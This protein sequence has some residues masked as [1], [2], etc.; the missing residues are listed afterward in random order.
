MK[1]DVRRCILSKRRAI[2]CA[3][4]DFPVPAR[5][6]RTRLRS[7]AGSFTQLTM[8]FRKAVRVPVRQPLSGVNREPIPY[9]ISLIFA[10]SS[11]MIIRSITQKPPSH[12]EY[13]PASETWLDT[14]SSRVDT[15]STLAESIPTSSR[16]WNAVISVVMTAWSKKAL[17]C[18]TR[19][20]DRASISLVAPPPI[21]FNV[22]FPTNHTF[23]PAK[24][25][26]EDNI[27]NCAS[28]AYDRITSLQSQTS[29]SMRERFLACFEFGLDGFDSV[30]VVSE[31]KRVVHGSN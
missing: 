29:C 18:S 2:S 4:D 11:I 26:D 19:A 28:F 7:E 16:I 3:I 6:K 14:H 13:V 5:P 12:Q 9:G 10:S 20:A 23:T 21:F 27:Q 30:F 31:I 15:Q 24:G 22:R 25:G 8:K 1:D 17:R